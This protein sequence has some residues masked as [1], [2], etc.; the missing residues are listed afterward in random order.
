MAEADQVF[1]GRYARPGP[2]EEGGKLRFDVLES[3]KGDV[4]HRFEM[5][6][7]PDGDCERTFQNQEL[8]VVFISKGH[9]PVCSGNVDIDKAL[10]SL[11]DYLRLAGHAATEPSWE[12]MKV[13]LTGRVGSARKLKIYSPP[14]KGKKMAVGS[15]QVSFIDG[16]GEDLYAASGVTG[17]NVSYV[18]LRSPQHVAIYL[19]IAR[20]QGKLSVVYAV[21]RDL[22]LH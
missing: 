20:V 17:N 22:K 13:A 8:A 4:P 19:L 14:L 5:P 21:K 2:D 6:R 11:G 3:L 16:N 1:I 15:T 7:P 10:P 9:V 12:A 18:V